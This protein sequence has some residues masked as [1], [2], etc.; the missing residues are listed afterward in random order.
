MAE[1]VRQV[2]KIREQPQA[3]GPL[4]EVAVL[5]GREPGGDELARL[6]D[7]DDQAV[8]RVGEHAGTVGGLLGARWRGRGWSQA[9]APPRS[10]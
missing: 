6:A 7:G 8:T 3:V 1:R 9:A 10:G 4:G 2:A 5:V